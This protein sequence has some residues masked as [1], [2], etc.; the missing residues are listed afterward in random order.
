[1]IYCTALLHFD[2]LFFVTSFC[3][4][5]S[6]ISSVFCPHNF[7]TSINDITQV[8]LFSSYLFTTVNNKHE[9]CKGRKDVCNSCFIRDRYRIFVDNIVILIFRHVLIT[10]L[11]LFQQGF[12]LLHYIKVWNRSMVAQMV[13][14]QTTTPA[15]LGSNLDVSNS[16]W[17]GISIY[18]RFFPYIRGWWPWRLYRNIHWAFGHWAIMDGA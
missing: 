4:F 3:L 5:C 17:D 10:Q 6:L 7:T 18:N 11:S 16:S 12:F 13:E 9:E 14:Q 15:D 2:S 8:L 1:M